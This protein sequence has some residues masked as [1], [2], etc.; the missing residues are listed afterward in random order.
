MKVTLIKPPLDNEFLWGHLKE[1]GSLQQPLGIAYLAAYVRENGYDVE[2]IDSMAEGLGEEEI[3][4]RI[5]GDLVGITASTIEITSAVSLAK[6]IKKSRDVPVIIGGPHVSALPRDVMK[7][8]C[9]DAGIVGE[10]EM[11]L[12]EL[13]KCFETGKGLGDVKG[14]AY[15]SKERVVITKRRDLICDL[16]SL[17]F[18]A[19]DLLLPLYFYKPTPAS[20]RKTPLGSLITS[21]GC[22]YRCV[23][24]DKGVFGQVYRARSPGNIADEIEELINKYGAREL[25]FWDDVIN[26]DNE[27]MVGICK[28]IID[29]GIDIEWSC[30]ARINNINREQL[31]WMKKA[32]CWQISYGLES[33]NDKILRIINKGLTTG[34]VRNVVRMTKRF[35]IGA[36]GFFM[37][38]LPGENE[39]TMRDTIDFAKSIPLDSAHFAIATPYPNT[40]MWKNYDIRIG[41]W[42]QLKHHDPDSIIFTPEELSQ[43]MIRKYYK[44]AYKEFYLRPGFVLRR[45]SEMRNPRDIKINYEA[46]KSV[47]SI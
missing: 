39:G 37:L 11:T 44:K 19:R 12:I 36:R 34:M 6:V 38:G 17:P 8:R 35:G 14:I 33:G 18:P 26:L 29:R 5:H 9:F 7:N 23:Y 15:R 27:R 40:E 16:D 20:N 2:I 22:P 28:E 4:S 47:V 30:I 46:L 13:V 42:D 3:V 31:Y 43:G 41:S 21:R 45:I 1:V 10:G 24:C 32:G 25:R